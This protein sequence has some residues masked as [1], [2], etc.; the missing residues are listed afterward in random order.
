MSGLSRTPG[1]RVGVNS[2]PR[3]RIL[4][5]P[6]RGP[7][8]AVTDSQPSSPLATSHLNACF[9][10]VSRRWQR[11]GVPRALTATLNS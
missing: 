7:G 1:K 8:F 4:L 9:D 11:A 6:P 5:S 3:V 2:P 10:E